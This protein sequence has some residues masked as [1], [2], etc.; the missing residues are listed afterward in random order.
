MLSFGTNIVGGVT[1][2][3]GGQL[4]SGIPVFDTVSEA[5][6]EVH[7]NSS[8]I[9]V[10]ADH[11]LEAAMESMEAGIELLVVVTEH[12]PVHDALK[13]RGRAESL[14]I[15]LIGPN[16]P[17]LAIPD[18]L[19]IGIMPNHIFKKGNVAVL[20]RS[21]TLTYEIVNGLT[22]AGIGQSLV[23]GIGGDQVVGSSMASIANDML[24]KER[25]DC[26][27]LIGEI[28]GL[29]EQLAAETIKG[30]YDG[31]IVAY[32]AGRTAPP[33]KRMGHAGAII[34]DS[35]ESYPKKVSSLSDLGVHVCDHLYDVPVF[36][37]KALY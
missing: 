17:G 9:F 18:D 6:R 33:G 10:P 37:K 4:M 27:V 35:S 15:T 19:K 36:V 13:M 2:G 23:V 8:A 31:P 7:A 22:N 11:C 20:S 14:G 1:P 30:W 25:P 3:K 32:I 16:S 28:G 12:V 29:E 34:G 21:G 5:V 26:I 24:R